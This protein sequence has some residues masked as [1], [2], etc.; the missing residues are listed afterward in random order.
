[1]RRCVKHQDGARG[2]DSILCSTS[3][4]PPSYAGLS[5]S[6]LASLSLDRWPACGPRIRAQRGPKFVKGPPKE[7]SECNECKERRRQT[8]GLAH[9]LKLA[10]CHLPIRDSVQPSLVSSRLQLKPWPFI[11]TDLLPTIPTNSISSTT[12]NPRNERAPSL[13]TRHF[14]AAFPSFL[15][16]P[17]RRPQCPVAMGEAAA[18][19]Y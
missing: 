11:K 7:C 8:Q 12:T 9:Q 17:P 1:M 2:F 4:S 14:A 16:H 19:I 18:Y 10:P 13:G 15:T 3:D 6:A 5:M